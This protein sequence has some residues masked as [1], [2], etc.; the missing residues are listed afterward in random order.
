MGVIF[1]GVKYDQCMTLITHPYLV[2]TSRMSR[3]YTS[4]LPCCLHGGSGTVL[5]LYLS[6]QY[7]WMHNSISDYLH[8]SKTQNMDVGHMLLFK[9]TSDFRRKKHIKCGMCAVKRCVTKL[10]THHVMGMVIWMLKLCTEK[11][12]FLQKCGIV[13]SG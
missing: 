13:K 12:K 5:L 1:L 9:D 11:K 6:V 3:G 4:S 8:L 10:S 7:V 2:P